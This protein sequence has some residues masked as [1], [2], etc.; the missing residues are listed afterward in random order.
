MEKVVQNKNSELEK[1]KTIMLTV[2]E[3]CNIKCS[4]CYEHN[5][6]KKKM[7]FETAKK[8]IDYEFSLNDGFDEIEVNFFGGEPFL[9][10]ELLKKIHDYIVSLEPNKRWICFAI[11]NGTK[12]HGEIQEWLEKHKDTFCVGFSLDGTKAMHD[13]NRMNSF[14]DIDIPFF[15]RCWPYQDIKMTVSRETLPFLAE[16]IKYIQSLGYACAGS[17]AYDINWNLEEDL[18]ILEQQL[19]ILAD[20]YIENPEIPIAEIIE[21]NI[22]NIEYELGKDFKWCGAGKQMF[23][24]DTE[25]NKFPCQFFMGLSIGELSKV[26]H[27]LFNKDAKIVDDKCKNCEIYA[28]CPTCYGVNY[29]TTGKIYERD[30]PHCEFNK[31]IVLANAKIKYHR[32]IAKGENIT[33]EDYYILKAIK[34]INDIF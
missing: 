13:T 29:S 24:Y 9:E 14:D 22:Q 8:I 19:N 17:F 6:T 27:D 33:D 5:K 30:E 18:P 25:G 23:C 28:V 3:S 12:V 31:R 20:Y 32:I 15:K 2:T 21:R 16:G 4:Y 1:R 10:F 34:K 26:T 7:S 11:T